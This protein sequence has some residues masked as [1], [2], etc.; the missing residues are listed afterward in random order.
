[1]KLINNLFLFFFSF[2]LLSCNSTTVAEIDIDIDADPVISTKPNILLVIADD[3]GLDATPSFTEGNI[4]P[5]MQI[6]QGL[7]NSGITFNNVWSYAVCTPTRASIL[8]GKYGIKTGILE[9]GDEI[10][11]T[12]T[13]IQ[14]YIDNNTVNAYSHAV[15]GKWHLSANVSSPTDMGV[16]Y[17]AGLLTGGVQSYT[18][19]NLTE[20]E[21]TANSTVYTTTKF[22]DLAIDWVENQTKPWFL[23]L[24]YNAPHTPFHLAPTDLHSQGNLPTDVASI[25]SNPIPY[26]MSALE[27]MDTELGRLLSS[28]SVE[29][30]ANTIIIFIGDNGSPNEVAQS[31]Y[32]RRKAKNSLYQG[33]I[34][35][36][37]VVSGFGVE[38]IG[39]REAA[40]IHT[41]DL[42]MTVATIAGVSTSNLN[43]SQSFYSLLSNSN[44]S[45]REFVYTEISNN[46]LGFAIRNADYKLIV[47]E[48]GIEEL[49]HL[50]T[51]A[52]ETSNLIGT[53]LSEEATSAKAILEIIPKINTPKVEIYHY[54]NEGVLSWY[55]FAK[56]IMNMAKL[57][58]KINAIETYEYPTPAKR[59][60]YSV[61]NKAKIKKDFS[62]K[63]P[64]WRDG[65][66]E[67]L[68]ELGERK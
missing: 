45:K 18:N 24:A 49:Y 39:V 22:T 63:V 68:R 65:L 60:S 44:A 12:E 29:E 66:D 14:K 26:Y 67:C 16:G 27:A 52:Y 54:S 61:L 51:D 7:M 34:N 6:L 38:R 59:P 28:L 30:R 35:V 33:G 40:L 1:M 19:W 56:E 48:N 4:K 47:Y 41:T 10:S 5:N 23:W 3:M 42:F 2:I 20:N 25:E 8:T 64:Y 31:P 58:C 11:S 37:M 50:T 13:S 62:L 15:I 36:P 9:V 53:T 55:D 43:N 57:S 17:Y 32:S 46:G 21:Q